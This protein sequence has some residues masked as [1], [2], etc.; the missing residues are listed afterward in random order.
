MAKIEYEPVR[1]EDKLPICPHCEEE[2]DTINYYER[3]GFWHV[4]KVRVFVCPHCNK[5]LGTGMC[6]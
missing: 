3:A 5:V 4:S 2:M 6:A 1:D